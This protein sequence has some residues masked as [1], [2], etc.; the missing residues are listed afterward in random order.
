[1]ADIEYITSSTSL[2]TYDDK[3][4]TVKKRLEVFHEQADALK[5]Y[6][7]STGKLFIVDGTKAPDTVF[8]ECRHLS[9]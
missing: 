2:S 1:M 5:S 8:A 6:Y 7:K 9:V 3:E 4:E